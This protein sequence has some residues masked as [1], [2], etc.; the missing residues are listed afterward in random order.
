[1]TDKER[2][3]HERQEQHREKQQVRE[4]E[5]RGWQDAANALKRR[6]A[7]RAKKN[8]WPTDR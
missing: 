4:F 6:I 3:E 5:K 1:M 8:N 2:K 7:K